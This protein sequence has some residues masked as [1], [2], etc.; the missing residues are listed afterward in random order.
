MKLCSVQRGSKAN[1]QMIA[2]DNNYVNGCVTAYFVA[3]FTWFFV[4]GASGGS[5]ADALIALIP[6][7]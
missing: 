6:A 4:L 3:C 7:F 2:Q 5:S 1:E